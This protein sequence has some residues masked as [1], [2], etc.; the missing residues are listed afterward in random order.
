MSE[1]PAPNDVLFYCDACARR[2]GRR[3]FLAAGDQDRAMSDGW[4]LWLARRG[5][6]KVT[7]PLYGGRQ[8]PTVA[9]VTPTIGGRLHGP[10]QRI[11]PVLQ[12]G[13]HRFV[14][15]PLDVAAPAAELVCYRNVPRG[16]RQHRPRVARTMLVEL[17]EQTI[18][19][20]RCDA[21]V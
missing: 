14:L 15:V 9:L 13:G 6:R 3:R 8:V 4:R 2:S 10:R 16:E 1:Q 5:G 21:Y 20:G 11:G 12:P 19:S 18:A 7:V 17:A